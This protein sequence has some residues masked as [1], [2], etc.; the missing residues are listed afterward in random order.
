[1]TS[2]GGALPNKW[3]L[4]ASIDQIHWENNMSFEH[5]MS[6]NEIYYS[7]WNKGTYKCYKLNM[8]K[9][10]YTN[11]NLRCSYVKQIEVFGTY[12]TNSYTKVNK[13]TRERT[14]INIRAF[15]FMFIYSS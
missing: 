2:N 9:N 11:Y 12:Y 10:V 8:L 7:T 13:C 3:L 4:A 15:I 6:K 14:L 1:M 5:V